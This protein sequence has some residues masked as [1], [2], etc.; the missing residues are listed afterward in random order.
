MKFY[1]ALCQNFVFLPC[2]NIIKRLSMDGQ[3][4]WTKILN[5]VKATLGASTFKTWFFGTHFLALDEG[6]SKKS[7]R[8][9]LSIGVRNNFIKEQ[10]EVRYKESLSLIAARLAG[11]P[12]DI[13]FK[14]ST[15]E[16]TRP[17]DKPIFSGV[18]MG[19]FV[20]N[21]DADFLSQNLTF[22]NFVVGP[23]NNIA[24]LCAKQVSLTPGS[25]YN[26][27]LVYGPTGVG[28]THLLQAIATEVYKNFEEAKVLYVS[29]EKF[30]NDY[31]DSL[32]NRAQAVFRN[33][34]RNLNLLLVDDIQFFA[35]KESTQDE[36][37]HTF[38]DLQ[39]SSAQIVLACDRHPKELGKLKDRLTSRFLGGMTV[40]ISQPDLEM[41]IAI[42]RAKC[43]EVGVTLEAD[44]L[45]FIA[46]SSG[47]SVRELEGMLTSVISL[48]K[49]S[50]D[51]TTLTQIKEI[52]RKN[53]EQAKS[54]ATSEQII[55]AVCNYYKIKEVHLLGSSRR[56]T[57]VPPRQILMYLLRKHLHLPLSE[58][59]QILG[60]RDHS[61][62][63]YGIEKVQQSISSDQLKHDELLRLE[64]VIS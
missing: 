41:K 61:T 31:I 38:N 36:F 43:Q 14:I 4:L 18:P 24:F 21:R 58:I 51:E 27:F 32:K 34:Y 19:V 59:G 8:L 44:I 7:K 60:G 62:V 1:N 39:L 5:E 13:D 45:N 48:K 23:S 35:G 16:N 29:A 37:F 50:T 54:P 33:K 3:K 30:T 56:A 20:K 53:L 40:D 22:D 52:F 55:T 47:G 10:V 49:L 15:L 11:C 28:K 25:S 42:I 2:K 26:P 63:I 9:S 64:A 6:F 17:V 12:V 57:L 46:S